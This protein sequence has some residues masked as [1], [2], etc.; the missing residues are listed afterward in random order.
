MSTRAIVP[1]EGELAI[2]FIDDIPVPTDISVMTVTL[3][4][5]QT[6]QVRFLVNSTSLPARTYSGGPGPGF[7]LTAT[8]NGALTADDVVAN[9]GDRVLALI[10]TGNGGNPSRQAVGIYE[11]IDTGSA[12][13]PWVMTR[14]TDFDE[15]SE[16]IFN[17]KVEVAEGTSFGLSNWILSRVGTTGTLIDAGLKMNWVASP[18]VT[19]DILLFLIQDLHVQGNGTIDGRLDITG[20]LNVGGDTDLTGQIQASIF[21]STSGGYVTNGGVAIPNDLLTAIPDV[22]GGIVQDIEAR[23]GLNTLLSRLRNVLLEP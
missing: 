22:S 2:E 14:A 13:S 16:V 5:S 1:P 3:I 18:T 10:Q 20:N 15:T 12:G 9:V 19:L 7:T 4:P 6:L 23:D 21:N 8:G 17:T 11:V